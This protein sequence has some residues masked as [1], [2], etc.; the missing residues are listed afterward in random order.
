MHLQHHLAASGLG[1]GSHGLGRGTTNGCTD[2]R[3]HFDGVAHG[4]LQQSKHNEQTSAFVRIV[5]L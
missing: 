2:G 1:G 5:H 3:L 4:P